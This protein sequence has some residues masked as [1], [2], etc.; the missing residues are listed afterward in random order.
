M[1]GAIARDLAIGGRELT[2]H[3]A[4][5]LYL[6]SEVVEPEALR[7]AVAEMVERVCVAPRDVLMR[8]KA[9]ALRRAGWEAAS[10]TL[11]L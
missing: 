3:E 2:A 11:D 5:A 9:K 1:G 6:V 8:T 10:P 7:G 4:L